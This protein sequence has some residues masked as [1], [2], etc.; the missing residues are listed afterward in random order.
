M[1]AAALK[2][3]SLKYSFVP[4]RPRLD[5]AVI[6]IRAAVDDADLFCFRIAKDE[7]VM[8]HHVHLHDGFLYVHRLHGEALRLDDGIVLRRI[9]PRRRA[10]SF[11]HHV[12]LETAPETPL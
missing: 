11:R 5:E 4:S 2:N 8:V 9:R 1:I 7:E 10:G 6:A 3:L 12:G